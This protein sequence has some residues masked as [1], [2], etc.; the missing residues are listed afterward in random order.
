MTGVIC[1]PHLQHQSAEPL[2]YF[3]TDALHSYCTLYFYSQDG[4]DSK[5]NKTRVL[6]AEEIG[7]MID[8][9]GPTLYRVNRQ[10][11]NM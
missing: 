5:N 4:L 8:A 2:G 1:A 6:C 10:V 3:L 9:E 11:S 7:S